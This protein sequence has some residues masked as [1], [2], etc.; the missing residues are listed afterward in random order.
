MSAHTVIQPQARMQP[1]FTTQ[2]MMVEVRIGQSQ[3]DCPLYT[4][5]RAQECLRVTGR[6]HAEKGWPADF[7][8]LSLEEQREIPTFVLTPWSFPP[9]TLVQ[10]RVL[11]A[12]RHASSDGTDA[13]AL[14]IDGWTFVTV[15]QI[16][17][18]LASCPSIEQL[19]PARLALLQT[20]VRAQTFGQY[21]QPRRA[22]GTVVFCTAEEA[23]RKL[24]E[25]RLLLK[26]ERRM[27]APTKGWLTR[28]EDEHP[29]VWR[30]IE[31]LS[32]AQRHA[33]VE[34]MPVN[35]KAPF[36]QAEHLIRFVP[37]RFQHALADLLLPDERLLVF[38]ERPLLR[39][40][41]G[42]LGWQQWR[43]NQGL[44]LVTDRQILWV[45]DFFSPGTSFLEGGYMAHAAPLERLQN[46]TRFSVG[47]MP[48]HLAPH[49]DRQSAVY[50][51]LVMEI[52]SATGVEYFVVHF[53]AREEQAIA[54]VHEVLRAWL[55]LET[56]RVDRR[57]RRVPI[58]EPWS[59]SGAEAEKLT[60]LGGNLPG[61]Q[62]ERLERRLAELLEATQEELL[63][64]ALVPALEDSHNPARLVALTRRA[65]VVL[66]DTSTHQRRKRTAQRE[67]IQRYD[68]SAI[69]SVQ[70]SYS[71]VGSGLRL[72]LPQSDGS[73]QDCLLPFHSPAM[74]WFRPL[75]TRLRLLLSGPT[76]WPS[77]PNSSPHA[78]DDGEFLGLQ[79]QA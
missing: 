9:G 77:N 14:P 79:K 49:L 73:L 13:E 20:A 28:E 39:H 63:A 42:F 55:P 61:E 43:S 2:P 33:L 46:V 52:A 31:G 6:H 22:R 76:Q 25:T 27:H 3:H 12:L 23:A 35:E 50:L 26:K 45:R 75:F 41:C 68:L 17:T 78:G 67:Q 56:G 66:E 71:L 21:Q 32:L 69:S 51:R 64:S 19:P 5:D 62:K 37:Q 36:A 54:K 65:V 10:A 30:A 74:A 7:A 53:P 16:D 40:R 18:D 15:A 11:G 58:V 34:G 59:P 44:F 24:R 38:V 57:V 60:G 70:L 48:E 1:P 29:L 8:M 72:F 4:W 47:Q